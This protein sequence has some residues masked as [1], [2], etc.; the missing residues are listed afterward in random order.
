MLENKGAGQ[1][2]ERPAEAKRLELNLSRTFDAPR[3]LVWEAWTRAEHVAQWFTPRPLTTAECKVDF[4]PG[5]EFRIVMRMPDG[6]EHAFDGSFGEI[7]E[8]E[9]LTFSG[10]LPD[11]NEIHTLV[12]FAEQ[13]D[14]TV[15]SVR[16]TYAFESDATR[17]AQQG[18]NASLDQL[19][20]VVRA[21]RD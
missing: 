2:V 17:G 19:G 8:P 16:Q 10:K 5:G 4:R 1:T 13:G 9:R 14:K 18:W 6:A 15:L 11:G 12:T 3:R 21:L 20:E 7:V